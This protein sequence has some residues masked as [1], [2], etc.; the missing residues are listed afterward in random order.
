MRDVPEFLRKAREIY[1]YR[2]FVNDTPGSLCEVDAPKVVETIARHT[3]VVHVRPTDGDLERLLREVGDDRRPLCYR[4]EFLDEGLAAYLRE[5]GLPYV[6]LIEPGDFYRWVLPR[7]CAERIR[8]YEEIRRRDGCTVTMA[9]LESIR[10]EAD[11][12]GLIE[13]ALDREEADRTRGRR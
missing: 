9:D 3:V 6:A 12:L 13:E 5:T 10:D 1:G 2:H 11:F 7:L 8:R 4:E